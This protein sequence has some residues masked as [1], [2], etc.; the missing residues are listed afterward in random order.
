MKKTKEIDF[1][2]IED[3]QKECER[4]G[5]IGTRNFEDGDLCYQCTIDDAFEQMNER[6]N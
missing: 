6:D 4:C 5:V 2:F 1:T 3:E